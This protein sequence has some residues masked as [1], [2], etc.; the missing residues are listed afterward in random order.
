MTP[1]EI[2]S[3]SSLVCCGM[4]STMVFRR[5]VFHLLAVVK[6]LY[7]SICIYSLHLNPLGSG[8]GASGLLLGGGLSYLSPAH[9]FACDNY[10]SLDVVLPHG[11]LV[12]V[13]G[14]N[15]YSDLFR[16]LKGGGSRFGIVTK[17]EVNAIHTGTAADKNWFGGTVIV[18][19]NFSFI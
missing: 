11:E 14:I 3:R 1:S 9:G 13:T 12:T 4:K 15:Q 16:A 5:K 19:L 2:R 7:Q 10:R 8:V 17:F 18:C 6:R